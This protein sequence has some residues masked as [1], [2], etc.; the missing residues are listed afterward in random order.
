MK[1]MK[2]ILCCLAFLLIWVSVADPAINKDVAA[3]DE[4]AAV[5]Q[6]AVREGATTNI[7]TYYACSLHIDVAITSTTLH[8]GTKVVV[9]VSSNTTGDED[10]AD[11][12][13]F[14]GPAD[15]ANAESLAGAEAQGQTVLEVASTVGYYDE[16]ETRWIFILDDTVADSEMVFLVSHVANTSVTVQDGIANAHTAADTLYDIAETYIV[17]VPPEFNRVR[18]IFDNT[19]DSDGSQVHT[20]TR[21]SYMDGI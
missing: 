10:W 20:K 16:D 6:N 3:V 4:W 9:Q 8:A 1:K 5:A 15:T 2:K 19:F 12:Y 21:I 13:Q 17:P 18:V 11:Y 7:A 14:I